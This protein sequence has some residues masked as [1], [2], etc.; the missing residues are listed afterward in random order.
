MSDWRQKIYVTD[1]CTCDIGSTIV[2]CVAE[3]DCARLRFPGNMA[4]CWFHFRF[5][6]ERTSP[7]QKQYIMDTKAPC[8]G[9]NIANTYWYIVDNVESLSSGRLM[10]MRNCRPSRGIKMAVARTAFLVWATS[11]I[12]LSFVMSSLIM[13]TT[14]TTFIA[15]DRTTGAYII[16]RKLLSLLQHAM[17]LSFSDAL[18]A[19]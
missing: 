7:L 2:Y 6:S 4:L 19:P 13:F 16:H 3:V 8:K 5:S 14:N 12:C 15:M 18:T 1:V 9:T 11:G 10:N 17:I